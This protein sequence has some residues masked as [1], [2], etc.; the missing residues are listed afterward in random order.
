MVRSGSKL[1][2]Q[3]DLMKIDIDTAAPIVASQ[4]SRRSKM[5]FTWQKIDAFGFYGYFYYARPPEVC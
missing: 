1:I 5:Q 2:L 3:L 4:M